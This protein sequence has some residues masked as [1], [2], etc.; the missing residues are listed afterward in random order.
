MADMSKYSKYWQNGTAANAEKLVEK[1][2][3]KASQAVEKL[4]SPASQK[5]WQTNVSSAETAKRYNKSVSNLNAAD[6]IASMKEKGGAAYTRATSSPTAMKKWE[7]NAAPYVEVAQNISKN[8]K[9]IITEQDA[10]DNFLAL[11]RAM[12]KKKEEVG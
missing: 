8:K 3:E 10:V 5:A 1:Y 9:P 7:E 6:M 11:R 4:K 2:E 12:K